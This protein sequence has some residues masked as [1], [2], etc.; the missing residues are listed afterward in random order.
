MPTSADQL[1]AY[2]H[3]S[4]PLSRVLGA[5]VRQC[6]AAGAELTAPLEPNVNHRQTVF[7]GSAASLAL[8]AGWTWLHSRLLEGGRPARIV[9]QEHSMHYRRPLVGAFCARCHAPAPE[10]W[11]RFARA[12]ARKGI[13]RLTLRVELAVADT[14]EPAAFFEGE[15]VA[16]DER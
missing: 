11:D 12:F 13:G 3:Q 1:T 15:Y 16:L 10:A 8:L 7:G 5:T 2:L 14:T 9:I 6:D 4:I